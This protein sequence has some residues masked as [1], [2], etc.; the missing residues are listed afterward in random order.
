MSKVDPR[1]DLATET[2]SRPDLME[3]RARVEELRTKLAAQIS[4][5][6]KVLQNA[7]RQIGSA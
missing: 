6:E 7:R 3:Y 1:A 4:T 2:N 5:N